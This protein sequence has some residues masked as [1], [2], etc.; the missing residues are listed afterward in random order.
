MSRPKRKGDPYVSQLHAAR[1][2]N[3]TRHQ[4]LTMLGNGALKGDTVAGRLVVLKSSLPATAKAPAPT[5]DVA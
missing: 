2:L 4:V 3:V 1:L 5:G